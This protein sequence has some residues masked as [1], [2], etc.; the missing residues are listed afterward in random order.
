MKER[1]TKTCI[2]K[3]KKIIKKY[4]KANITDLAAITSYIFQE[5]K[6]LVCELNEF[7]LL[8]KNLDVF[9]KFNEQDEYEIYISQNF[10]QISDS[11]LDW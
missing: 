7:N 1:I 3:C 6:S 4:Q 10:I 2:F 9:W 11:A 5:I 8:R